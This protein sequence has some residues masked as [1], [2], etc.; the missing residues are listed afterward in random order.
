MTSVQPAT[1]AGRRPARPAAAGRGPNPLAAGV[2]VLLV[3]LVAGCLFSGNGGLLN[4]TFPLAVLLGA[5]VLFNNDRRSWFVLVWWLWL[6]TPEVRRLSDWQA[7]YHATSLIQLAPLLAMVVVVPEMVGRLSGMTSGPLQGFVLVFAAIG[8]GTVVGLAR[9]GIFSAVYGA[10]SW[11]LPAAMGAWLASDP[12]RYRVFGPA[13]VRLAGVSTL[14]VGGYGILQFYLYPVWDQAWAANAG[15]AELVGVKAGHFRPFSTLNSAGPFAFVLMV[16][17]ILAFQYRGLLRPVAL[18]VGAV[19]LTITRVRSVWGLTVIALAYLLLQQ[20]KDLGRSL[21]VVVVVVVAVGVLVTQSGLVGGQVSKRVSQTTQ[22]SSDTS[23][24]TR[25]DFYR[26]TGPAVFKDPAGKGIGSTGTAT[27]L[28]SSTNQP[29]SF[30]GGLLDLPYELGWLGAVL[31]VVGVVMLTRR[32]REVS[33][34]DGIVV[35]CRCVGL[36][37]GL[38]MLFYSDLAGV[39]GFF[40]WIPLGLVL[41]ARAEQRARVPGSATT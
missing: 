1:G 20:R 37:A 15:L 40:T 21:R 2:G 25:V 6:L 17:V 19:A 36:A 13:V 35:V 32:S 14:V 31:L 33:G 11:V 38:F 7:G 34:G 26:V 30:D 29:V 39:L 27:R 12:G 16:T 10:L 24:S 5:A 22:G 4:A 8:L 28:A 23:F 3:S 9:A 18:A 41:A